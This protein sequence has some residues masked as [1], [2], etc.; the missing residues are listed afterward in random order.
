MRHL[1]SSPFRLR[2][3]PN[4]I[5]T[6]FGRGTHLGLESHVEERRGNSDHVCE[7][8]PGGTR[9]PAEVFVSLYV[10]VW[11]HELALV[12][13]FHTLPPHWPIPPLPYA[14]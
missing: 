5:A 4:M 9:R 3:M 2:D 11:R 14:P 10:H 13:Q 6:L 8:Q 7:G 1:F 12:Q